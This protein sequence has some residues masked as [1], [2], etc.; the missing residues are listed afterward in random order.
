MSGHLI[1]EST[2]PLPQDVRVFI[3]D[4]EV[5]GLM[6]LSFLVRG[7]E[8]N[9]CLITFA[10]TRVTIDTEALLALTAYLEAQGS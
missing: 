3:D 10:P 8:W 2:G 5:P 4:W 9:Q 7:D 1:I 6:S